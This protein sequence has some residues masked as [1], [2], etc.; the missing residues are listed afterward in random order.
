M[1]TLASLYQVALDNGAKQCDLP[2]EDD[3]EAVET[4]VIHPDDSIEVCDVASDNPNPLDKFSLNGLSSQYRD[5]MEEDVFVLEGIALRGQITNIYA[6][7]GSGKTLV[8]LR[9]LMKLLLAQKSGILSIYYINADD[10][11]RGLTEKLKTAEEY[12]FEMLAPGHKGFKA[13]DLIVFMLEMIHEGQAVGVVIILDTIKKFT[14][15]M[16][17]ADARKFWNV[18]RQFVSKGGTLITLAHANKNLSADGKPIY[19]GTSD[20]LDD[21]DCA[22]TLREIS[23]N[24]I[25]KYKVVE[26]ENIKNRG[27]VES[28]VC[29]QYSTEEGLSYRELLETVEKVDCESLIQ[30][31]EGGSEDELIEI[32]AECITDG[33]NKKMALIQAVSEH[34]GVSKSKVRKLIEHHTGDDPALHKWGFERGDRGAHVFSLLPSVTPLIEESNEQENGC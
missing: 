17:K 6:A 13:P 8:T 18:A 10:C 23:R 14:D 1:I 31:A 25:E 9:L 12:G 7:P 27:M 3:F 4:V 2:Q 33:I 15:P 24:E 34:S 29:Y 11:H 20:S 22:F 28:R 30:V 21:T 19:A 26:F 16:S 32:V 5:Q